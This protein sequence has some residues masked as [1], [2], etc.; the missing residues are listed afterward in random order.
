MINL[1]YVALGRGGTPQ[2]RVLRLRCG[3]VRQGDPACFTL[4]VLGGQRLARLLSRAELAA[5]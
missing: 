3:N 5:A 1:S 4:K 2:R